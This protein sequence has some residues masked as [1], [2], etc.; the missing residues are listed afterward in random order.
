MMEYEGYIRA[1]ASLPVV[2]V[3]ILFFRA[4]MRAVERED[5]F[6]E[7]S[8]K[9]FKLNRVSRDVTSFW[10]GIATYQAIVRQYLT[11]I[12]GV[13]LIVGLLAFY[14]WA[15][16]KL[17]WWPE[18]SIEKTK[19]GIVAWKYIGINLLKAAAVVIVVAITL[20]IW[21]MIVYLLFNA[22][23]YVSY[24]YLVFG[25][26]IHILFIVIWILTGKYYSFTLLSLPFSIGNFL[27]IFTI[28]LSDAIDFTI[29]FIDKALTLDLRA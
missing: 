4:K 7:M 12:I 5:L 18:F 20:A 23:I 9:I 19:D 1:I 25:S 28:I 17:D 16:W 10:E 14:C 11:L 8:E 26:L 27:S 22:V 13:L 6:E 3:T 24:L 15:A 2:I 29:L 21:G